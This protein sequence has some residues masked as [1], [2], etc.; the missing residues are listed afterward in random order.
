M[1]CRVYLCWRCRIRGCRVLQRCVPRLLPYLSHLVSPP[2]PPCVGIR[3]RQNSFPYIFCM[4]DSVC[5][6][7]LV[8]LCHCFRNGRHGISVPLSNPRLDFF[9][10]LATLAARHT[11]LSAAQQPHQ[12]KVFEAV[13]VMCLLIFFYCYVMF[14]ISQVFFYHSETWRTFFFFFLT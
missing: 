7:F 10:A 1:I 13:C 9:C 2:P 8:Y 4:R 6:C 12:R 5:I 14:F 11:R 3:K